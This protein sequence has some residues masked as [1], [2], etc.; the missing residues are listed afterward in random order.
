[1]LT[2]RHLMPKEVPFSTRCNPAIHQ[3][4]LVLQLEQPLLPRIYELHD[5]VPQCTW[6][7]SP[8]W[9]RTTVL[10]HTQQASSGPAK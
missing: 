9:Y 8:R 10:P 6:R 5:H 3:P 4:G 7:V 2:A 1:M